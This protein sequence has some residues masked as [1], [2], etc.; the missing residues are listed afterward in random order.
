VPKNKIV[1]PCLSA[2]SRQ[3]DRHRTT[4]RESGNKYRTVFETTGT[5]TILVEEDTIISLIN[6]EFE[7]LS[8]FPR[9]EVEGKKSFSEFIAD[10]DR[11]RLLQYHH[12]RRIDPSAAPREYEARVVDR[13]LNVKHVIFTVGMIPGTTTSVASILDITDRKQAENALRTSEERF[14]SLTENS[15]TGV[16]IIQDGQVAYHNTEQENLFGRGSPQKIVDFCGIHPDDV[17]G[18]RTLYCS[19]LS[20]EGRKG[21]IDF[22]FY[23][24]GE[25]D[26]LSRMRWIHCQ[27]SVITFDGKEAI[28]VNATDIT[29]IKE[30]EHLL[31][32]KARMASLGRVA[33]GI[34][35]ELRNSLSGLNIHLTNLERTLDDLPM[36]VPK[37][38]RIGDIVEQL[39]SV[40][41]RIEG[42]VRRVM[43]YAKPSDPQ[44][45]L[46]DINQCIER[47]LQLS[48]VT[49][50]DSGINIR[51]LLTENLPE[52]S[53]DCH[54][55]EQVIL[56]LITNAAQ[57][58]KTTEQCKIIEISS[59]VVND[60]IF[61]KVSDSGPGVSPALRDKIFDPFFTSDSG[62]T[63]LGLS[64]C[65][66]II[67]DHGGSLYLS[68]GNLGGAQF[69]I[70]LPVE[71][72][73]T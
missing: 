30:L 53:A 49:L 64:I 12:L 3:S 69:V 10:D 18:V 51:K 68:A 44:F 50:Q 42:V 54:M 11:E 33:A 31:R 27:A 48:S 56:N 26:E 70:E 37:A 5:A 29:H 66:R 72:V 32:I 45:A 34:A 2:S 24:C 19:M 23:P 52:C 21:D 20:G 73:R 41:N 71:K 36:E 39:R 8:G 60:S 38:Q 22:R 58:M 6:V 16:F 67:V 9:E 61:I 17:E 28:L 35:H 65:Q 55:I 43:D 63:G 7:K 40:S 4:S 1:N 57:A 46:G 15:P 62:G 47:A 25:V 59:S 13:K 14:R